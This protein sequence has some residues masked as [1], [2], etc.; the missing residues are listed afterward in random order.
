MVV[1]LTAKGWRVDQF[2]QLVF[3]MQ[4]VLLRWGP[5]MG[6]NVEGL[7][8]EALGLESRDLWSWPGLAMMG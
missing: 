2:V 6:A 8:L 7:G 4:L 5:L 1:L 3:M